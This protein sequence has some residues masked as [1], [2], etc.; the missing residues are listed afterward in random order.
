LD[1]VKTKQQ[2]QR[3]NMNYNL[4]KVFEENKITGQQSGSTESN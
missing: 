4:I 3:D 2:L 1:E